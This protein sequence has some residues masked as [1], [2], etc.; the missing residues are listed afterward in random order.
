M[1]SGTISADLR[2]RVREQAGNRCGYCL[3]RQEYV[4][5]TLEVEHITPRSK[6]GNR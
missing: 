2:A 6:G 1:P 5:W 4:P 3:T